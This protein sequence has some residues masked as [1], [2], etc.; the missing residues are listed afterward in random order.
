MEA[1]YKGQVLATWA[2]IRKITFQNQQ[3]ISPE[4]LKR[5]KVT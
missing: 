3:E 4:R 2:E 5:S 1:L